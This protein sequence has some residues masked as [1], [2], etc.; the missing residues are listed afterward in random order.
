MLGS[1]LQHK[2]FEEDTIHPMR[3]I[4]PFDTIMYLFRIY[5]WR[6]SLATHSSI[7]AWRIPWTGSLV[8]CK[9]SENWS[10]LA[11]SMILSRELSWSIHLSLRF[12]LPQGGVNIT[13]GGKT[14]DQASGTWDTV[15]ALPCWH[16][17]LGQSPPSV[18]PSVKWNNWAR[19]LMISKETVS[20]N[21][22]CV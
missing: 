13:D 7:L 18:F 21:I 10:D 3:G 15:L 16:F 4:M 5:P 11:Y 22:L 1:R 9:E 2:N 17:A 14:H 6:R 12:S 8:G 19:T 20:F